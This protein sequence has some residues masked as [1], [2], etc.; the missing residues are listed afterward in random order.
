MKFLEK[1]RLAQ[2][3]AVST[4]TAMLAACGG[5]SSSS[6]DS[7]S[8]D[9]S[10]VTSTTAFTASTACPNGG[11]TVESG[12]DENGNGVLD[13]SEV[14]N[15]QEVCNGS[16]GED[17]TVADH[18]TA[19]YG[20]DLVFSGVSAPATDAEKRTITASDAVINETVFGGTY[21][22]LARSGT[23][24]NGV[25]FGQLVNE[26]GT[27]LQS[28]DGSIN[29]T[30]SN[31]HT[32][33]LPIGDK[34]FSVSQMESTPGAMFLMELNQDDETGA[35]SVK[36]MTQI[37]QSGVNGGWVHCAASVTPWTTHLASEEYEPNARNPDSGQRGM[38]SYYE[39]E[40][41]W[42]PYFYGWNI[43]IEVSE[44]SSTELTKHYAMGRL[45][46][47][48][49]YVMP[50]SKTAYM[51]DDGTNVGF[52][53]FVADTAGD[54]SAGTLYAAK[55]TQTSGD[56]GGA[57]DISWIDLGHAS[58]DDILPYVVGTDTQAQLAFTDLFETEDVVSG[59]C[60]TDGFTYVNTASGGAECL[61][62]VDGMETLASRMETRRYAAV[63]GASIEFKKEEGVTFD[64][65]RSKLYVGMSSVGSGMSDTS[66]D[67]QLAE[68]NSCGIVYELDV[69][70]DTNIG[71]SYV[72]NNMSAMVLGRPVSA[73]DPQVAGY[74][75]NNSCH[76]DGIANPDNVTYMSGYDKLIIGED[77]GGGHQND[78]IWAYEFDDESLT[79]IQTTPYGA[80][81]TSPY[82]Y[83]NI[84][85]WAYLMSVVQH[86]YGESDSD[87][88]TGAG[89][90]YA[91][92]GYIGPF[93]G[94]TE[95]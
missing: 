34:L 21:N 3:V 78:V 32:S 15:T 17:L 36:N 87:K 66:G 42:N 56:N 71:S 69:A 64:P 35:L 46:F 85:G 81:T 92:T 77:T 22:T 65:V 67:I 16:D 95:E 2:A 39:D 20:T 90:E 58:D 86:P 7:T 9:N 52:F 74:E 5:S 83:P 25:T 30:N 4:L 62:V 91:Y 23:D 12:I 29:V 57:A 59:A 27:V 51:T 55:W 54:L 70:A 6:N 28:T 50:D 45:A 47:E 1:N 73:E 84:N 89:E 49:A 11:I 61:K 82:W 38:L 43:E 76:I 63:Q 41:D 93:P 18:T 14:D 53:M 60:S 44:D 72:A 19:T 37:D 68:G 13:A 31:E 8:G 75:D 80:E 79:R 26:S 40:A 94:V 48:L 24:Y 33:L 10:T 88:N